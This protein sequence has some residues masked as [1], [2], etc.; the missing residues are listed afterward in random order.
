[1]T[2]DLL[3]SQISSSIGFL[4]VL[5]GG[6]INSIGPSNLATIPLINGFVSSSSRLSRGHS[7]I[8]S[9][10]FVS[11]LAVTFMLSGIVMEPQDLR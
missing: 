6:V 1:M 9:L 11:E 8:L 7:F 5:L 10:A 2:F 3:V 4:L